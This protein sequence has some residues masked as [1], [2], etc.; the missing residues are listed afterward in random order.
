MDG[1][2]AAWSRPEGARAG[3]PLV[4]ALHGR[5]A[6]EASMLALAPGLPAG[7]TV[8]APRGPIALGAGAFTWFENRGIGRPV[9]AS[10]R[11]TGDLLLS[12]LDDVAAAHT[13]VTLLG[14]SGGTAMAGGLLLSEPRHFSAAVLLSGTLPW[15][16]G[17]DASEGRLDGMPVF[18][19]FDPADL[20]IPRD[21]VD[22]S[23]TWLRDG[24]GAEL[25]ERSYPGMGHAISAQE[26]ADVSD[27]VSAR[28][29]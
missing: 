11:A 13:S 25:V 12:W 19:A 17:L 5:G 22:R 4:V 6:N 3:T 28:S 29:R 23:E 9:E 7:V 21:L 8:A 27:F 1:L 26:L 16:A 18:W 10:I 20:V 24:S 14:F 15:D 2:M